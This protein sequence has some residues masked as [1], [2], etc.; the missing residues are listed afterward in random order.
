MLTVKLEY[1]TGNAGLTESCVTFGSYEEARK[2]A[3]K[4]LDEILEEIKSGAQA[5]NGI[6]RIW[7]DESKGALIDDLCSWEH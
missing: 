5:D 1:G 2:F 3:L 6:L 7:D 4:A